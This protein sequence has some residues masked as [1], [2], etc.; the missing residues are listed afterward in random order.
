MTDHAHVSSALSFVIRNCT[1]G[2]VPSLYHFCDSETLVRGGGENVRTPSAPPVFGV[3]VWSNV[4]WIWSRSLALENIESLASQVLYIFQRQR[5]WNDMRRWLGY[6]TTHL[7]VSIKC[8][9]RVYDGQTDGWTPGCSMYRTSI[10]SCGK[11]HRPIDKR[12]GQL[13][14][15]V[16]YS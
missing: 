5:P 9:R 12:D 8:H 15:L 6:I 4:I 2:F 11:S 13:G 16:S 7:A 3:P 14:E 10:A 1:V